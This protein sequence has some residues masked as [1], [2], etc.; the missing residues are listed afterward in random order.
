MQLAATAPVMPAPTIAMRSVSALGGAATCALQFPFMTQPFNEGGRSCFIVE[1]ADE[2]QQSRARA[3][4]ATDQADWE[5]LG[6]LNRTEKMQKL[7]I[8]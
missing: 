8:C 7:L 5:N 1:L 2:R 4:P 3:A 6:L